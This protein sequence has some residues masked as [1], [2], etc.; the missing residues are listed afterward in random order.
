M[1]DS[2]AA[3]DKLRVTSHTADPAG[4]TSKLRNTT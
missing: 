3:A 4:Y 2:Y 1:G